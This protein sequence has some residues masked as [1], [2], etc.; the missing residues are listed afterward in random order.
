V[1][2]LLFA[3]SLAHGILWSAGIRNRDLR[4]LTALGFGRWQIAATIAWQALTIAIISLAAGTALGEISSN[5]GWHLFTDRFGIDPG[6][7]S[8]ALQL[9][10][11]WATVL[12][13][14][15]VAGLCAMPAATRMR[16]LR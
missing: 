10:T 16:Q 14:A 4:I 15:V 9:L 6:T 1:L 5:A 11:I 2:G 12:V 3:I 13:G 7:W 8:S